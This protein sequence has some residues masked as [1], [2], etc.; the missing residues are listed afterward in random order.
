M[1]ASK[2]MWHK[3]D[4]LS[5]VSLVFMLAVAGFLGILALRIVPAYSEYR[6]INNAI[7]SAKAAGGGV[8]E[9]Q[10]AFD[11]AATVNYITSITG[12]DLIIGK[13]SGETEISFAYEKKIPLFGPA[14]LLLEYAGSTAADG[15][16]KAGQ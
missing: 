6:A 5:L 9:M 14:S 10:Q 7:K 4:G 8:R 16:P 11:N 1:R 2:Q 12:K 3:Q 13:E 15:A